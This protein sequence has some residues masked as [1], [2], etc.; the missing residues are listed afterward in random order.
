MYTKNT[1]TSWVKNEEIERKWH[2]V[3]VSDQVVG[4]AATQIASLLLGK[5]KVKR[6][7]NLDCGDHVVV[8]NTDKLK[9]TRGKELKKQYYRHSGYP[10]GL[11]TIRFDKQMK[12]DS[13]FVIET[14]IKNML[15]KDKLRDGRMQRLY[16][17]TGKE[18]N[19]N[20]QNPVEY[21]LLS[22]ISGR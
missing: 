16:L 20:A 18:H 19:H 3:D 14:A 9:L 22:K 2:I 11:K 12:K 7:P 1:R 5:K 21:K 15:P 4:R 17:F 8:I 10:G 13:R 6:V